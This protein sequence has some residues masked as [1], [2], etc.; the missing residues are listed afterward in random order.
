VSKE[1]SIR[2]RDSILDIAA[3]GH[4]GHI[5]S[6]FSIVEILIASLIDKDSAALHPSDRLERARRRMSSFVLSKGHAA[7]ALYAV[8]LEIGLLT[9]MDLQ[10]FAEKGSRFGG[11][12]TRSIDPPIAV[13]TGSLGHGLPVCAGMAF[14]ARVAGRSDH[15]ICLCGDGEL[16]EG[17]VWE[18]LLLVKKFGL[19]NLTLVVDNNGSSTRAV[20]L[21]SIAEKLAS[22]GLMVM[23]V[24]G[25]EIT[26][27]RAALESCSQQSVPTAI[28]ANT[29][30]GYGSAVT[31]NNFA[32][33]HRVPSI[34]DIKDIR[35]GYYI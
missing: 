16:N 33:H 26:Q 21:G 10:H 20:D 27:L 1:L 32:W 35:N 18:S 4:E 8:L 25:H 24:D 28:V 12:P 29:T 15:F 23:Q 13:S 14:S 5:A 3:R 30:K 31:K 22:F 17:S 9:D 11:H 19:R 2:I 34:S 7:L 6:S